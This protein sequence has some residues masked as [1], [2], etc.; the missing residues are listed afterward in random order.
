M[1]FFL[2]EHLLC[3]K[4]F[5]TFF[6][7][8]YQFHCSLRPHCFD[9][10]IIHADILCSISTNFNTYHSLSPRKPLQITYLYQ[11]MNLF[12][13]ICHQE[14]AFSPCHS[15]SRSNSWRVVEGNSTTLCP[16]FPSILDDITSQGCPRFSSFHHRDCNWG[17]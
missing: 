1:S 14:V 6:F 7:P 13:S 15:P 10:I 8:T 12:P 2:I 5:Q 16:I 4:Y 11:S 17:R 9:R 3:F